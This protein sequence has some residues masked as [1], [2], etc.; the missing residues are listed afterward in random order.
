M[1]ASSLAHS[2]VQSTSHWLHCQHIEPR[3]VKAVRL[4]HRKLTIPHRS[5]VVESQGI[6]ST[7]RDRR[8]VPAIL[9]VPVR[10]QCQ[11]GDICTI[12]TFVSAALLLSSHY[13]YIAAQCVAF[14][15]DEN[16]K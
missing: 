7:G 1:G 9:L 10:H 2:E 6:I 8:Q 15:G 12:L 14:I 4:T 13:P 16:A 11:Y 5:I 3:G